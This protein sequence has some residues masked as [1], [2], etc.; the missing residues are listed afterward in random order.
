MFVLGLNLG[1]T[2][3]YAP[4]PSEVTPLGKDFYLNVCPWSRP[5]TDTGCWDYYIVAEKHDI[6]KFSS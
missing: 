6:P 3:K 2:V 5:S 1:Y 4:L